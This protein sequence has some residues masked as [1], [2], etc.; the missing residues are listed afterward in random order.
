VPTRQLNHQ[1]TGTSAPAAPGST[2]D[3]DAGLIMNIIYTIIIA[4]CE[5]EILGILVAR[6]VHLKRNGAKS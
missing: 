5:A 3:V 4:L 1:H 2:I 6:V